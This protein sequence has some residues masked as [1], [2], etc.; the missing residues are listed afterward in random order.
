MQR[1]FTPTRPISTRS[2]MHARDRAGSYGSIFPR[3]FVSDPQPLSVRSVLHVEELFFLLTVFFLTSVWSSTLLNIVLKGG[4]YRTIFCNHTVGIVFPFA[5]ALT[6]S[7]FSLSE[8][9]MDN[10]ICCLYLGLVWFLKTSIMELWKWGPFWVPGSVFGKTKAYVSTSR[11][12]SAKKLGDLNY[13][14]GI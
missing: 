9:V 11:Y 5:R 13:F 3:F 7:F 14:K 4:I 12:H 8:K 1:L 2:W 10:C 6:Y